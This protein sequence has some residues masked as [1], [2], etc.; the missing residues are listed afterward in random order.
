MLRLKR[1]T[2]M[3]CTTNESNRMPTDTNFNAEANQVTNQEPV[4]ESTDS[5][6]DAVFALLVWEIW[7]GVH[8]AGGMVSTMPT[9]NRF[10]CGAAHGV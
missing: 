6:L 10:I 4:N 8:T 1:P 3:I 5:L 2:N 9:I 7:L